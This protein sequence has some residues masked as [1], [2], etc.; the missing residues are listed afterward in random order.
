M[1]SKKQNFYVYRA[2][3]GSGKTYTLSLKYIAQLLKGDSRTEHRKILAVTFTNDA[4]AEM[5]GRILEYLKQLS[6]GCAGDFLD[7]LKIELP[8][9]LA[10]D[11]NVI[12]QRAAVA[13]NAIL[14]DYSNFHV[15]TIDSFFQQ[16][17]RNFAKE[18]GIGS[19]FDIELN[20]DL[21]VKEAVKALI[22]ETTE[23]LRNEVFRKLTDF[24]EH[25]F[26]ENSWSIERDLQS[27]GKIIFKE[28]FQKNHKII[29]ND[30][31]NNP[32]KIKQSM[33]NCREMRKD[34]E[35]KINSF[36]DEFNA[37]NKSE[38]DSFLQTLDIGQKVTSG[39]MTTYFRN[40]RK[41]FCL[42]PTAKGMIAL[43][44][45]FS[46]GNSSSYV[47]MDIFKYHKDMLP[48]YNSACLFL[49]FIHQLIL[50]EDIAE[51][52]SIQNSEQ[53]RFILANTGQILSSLLQNG[54]AA[55]LFEKIGA[56]IENI[57]IDEFQDTSALQWQNF[58]VLIQE[59]LSSGTRFGLLVGDVKQSIYRWRG[60]DW[61]ILNNIEE[62]LGNYA[63]YRNL[64]TNHRSA[65]NIIEF[66]NNLFSTIV[67]LLQ[68]GE[69]AD[70]P[71]KKAYIDVEE[72]VARTTNGF[73]SVEF[74]KPNGNSYKNEGSN[75]M[76]DSLAIK[77]HELLQNGVNQSEICFLCRKNKQVRQIAAELPA[78]YSKL[79][80][81]SSERIFIISEDAYLFGSSRV[82]RIL[83]SALRTINDPADS[84]SLA[85]LSFLLSEDKQNFFNNDVAKK[86]L[87]TYEIVEQANSS[88][89]SGNLYG[90]IE[91]LIRSFS[92][93]SLPENSPFLFAFMDRLTDYVSRNQSDIGRFLDYWDEKLS[94]ETL[95]VPTGKNDRR[96]GILALTVH[97]S[98]GLQFHTV[99]VPFVDW[100]MAEK[101]SP[102]KQNIVWSECSDKE[103]PFDFSLLPIEYNSQMENSLFADAFDTETQN[104]K[105]DNL[106]VLYVA[107]TR[108]ECNLIILAK[109]PSDNHNTLNI[110]DLL[111]DS[112]AD[113]LD[114]NGK[115]QI[116]V[117]EK[118]RIQSIIDNNHIT[119]LY[120]P[121]IHN[122][123]PFLLTEERIFATNDDEEVIGDKIS[124][125]NI[126]HHIFENIDPY[127][128]LKESIKIAIDQVI[129]TGELNETERQEYNEYV[130]R[131]FEQQGINPSC[132]RSWISDQYKVLQEKSII[133]K[134][135]KEYRPDLVLI[136]NDFNA[137]VVDF[138]TGRRDPGHNRQLDHYISLIRRMNNF[139]SVDGKLWYLLENETN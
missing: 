22:D 111:F 17:V 32:L 18:L 120:D 41:D 48:L 87:E 52:V 53:N 65:R 14:H 45:Y 119:T 50:I 13:F 79:F 1:T 139:K 30:F 110:Q 100:G 68:P 135:G 125:G 129:S 19:R 76:I 55:F 69:N 136:D 98:K 8:S 85:E 26:E 88:S 117:I 95:P 29:I 3:A 128:P 33:D 108:A 24:V 62:E 74:I 21:P 15:T 112:F 12:R 64:D 36:I 58:R 49:R 84:V 103:K 137:T 90:L 127:K 10:A 106:N 72:R 63:V 96:D 113:K 38:L 86:L 2:S 42:M 83:I 5:K 60:S 61:R 78:A 27:F 11:D 107:L 80:P 81:E 115:Y 56:Q 9:A 124:R 7:N 126:I 46:V 93:T 43:Y 121:Q 40:L 105:M 35:N 118:S 102:F 82:L 67:S 37:T 20:T 138:K 66:N 89:S 6:E 25:K 71:Y 16:V 97:K 73:V 59:I 109:R 51:K 4:A 23:D 28:V 123:N 122:F 77:T 92:L 131:F 91:E 70:L 104:L 44:E 132:E 75:L 130:N 134:D 54:D 133:T 116:G 57:V 99:V 31:K 34:F 39:N 101:S 114:N 94:K 47:F